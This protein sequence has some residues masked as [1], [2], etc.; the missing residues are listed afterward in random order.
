MHRVLRGVRLRQ[1]VDDEL[2]RDEALDMDGIISL[3]SRQDKEKA[4]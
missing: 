2:R 1:G 3:I 4:S